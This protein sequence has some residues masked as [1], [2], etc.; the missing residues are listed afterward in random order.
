MLT[1]KSRDYYVSYSKI[2]GLIKKRKVQK[3][4]NFPKKGFMI[5]SFS[6]G[7]CVL[8]HTYCEKS[9]MN[10]SGVSLLD[11]FKVSPEYLSLTNFQCSK[12]IFKSNKNTFQ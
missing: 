2:I 12:L 9:H 8:K 5:L 10:L 1:R 7:Y 3:V 4:G 11:Q 6:H